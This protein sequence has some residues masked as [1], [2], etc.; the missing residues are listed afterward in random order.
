M[1][2]GYAEAYRCRGEVLH[3]Q[4]SFDQALIAYSQANSIDKDFESYA[5]E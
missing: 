3:K 5:G 1:D 4:E 2:P